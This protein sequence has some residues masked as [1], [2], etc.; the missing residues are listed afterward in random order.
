MR[1]SVVNALAMTESLL[2]A[3]PP[4][5]DRLLVAEAVA[6]RLRNL[7]GTFVPSPGDQVAEWWRLELP[8]GE[9]HVRLD[10][11][12]KVT[13]LRVMTMRFD[14]VAMVRDALESGGLER[15]IDERELPEFESG[16]VPLLVSANLPRQRSPVLSCGVDLTADPVPPHR[17]HVLRETVEFLPPDDRGEVLL[18]FAAGELATYTCETFVMLGTDSRV[19][20]LRSPRRPHAGSSTWFT[21]SDFALDW[22]P[23]AASAQLLREGAVTVAARWAGQAQ[24][25]SLTEDHPRDTLAIPAGVEGVELELALRR[26]GRRLRVP[27]QRGEHALLGLPM[28]R[29]FGPHSV[30][31]S[32]DFAGGPDFVALDVKP[33]DEP[34]SAAVTVSFSRAR[35]ARTWN[36]FAPSP[37]A[38]GYR[39]RL[40]QSAA[41]SGRWSEPQSAFE[42]LRLAARAL[43]GT[44]SQAK[45]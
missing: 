42:A 45:T 29:E 11:G 40:F 33:E 7:Y 30:E 5:V 1:E 6:D 31:I 25:V 18:R 10:L 32:V 4:G 37:F 12:E 38:P 20:E 39:Y 26:G 22:I 17:M 34:D 28:F 3:L 23:V 44:G 41:P 13:A 9:T 36:W 14:P 43:T 15:L 24:T 27:V 8:A 35:P 19:I 21:V 16:F 2:G